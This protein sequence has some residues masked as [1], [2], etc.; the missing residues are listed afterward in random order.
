MSAHTFF[1]LPVQFSKFDNQYFLFPATDCFTKFFHV[2]FLSRIQIFLY[3]MVYLMVPSKRF[4]QAKIDSLLSFIC[5]LEDGG[6]S[7]T[8]GL[9]RVM[10]YL[11][12]FP[13]FA[14]LHSMTTDR[15]KIGR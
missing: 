10:S 12:V 15:K 5:I 1:Q 6:L 3:V 7:R 9:P 13:L 8:T 14:N 2:Q 11:N 4:H